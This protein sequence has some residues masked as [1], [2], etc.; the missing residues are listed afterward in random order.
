MALEHIIVIYV[1]LWHW[2]QNYIM[3]Y[4]LS[5]SWQTS[6]V[7]HI[8]TFHHPAPRPEINVF[9]RHTCILSDS[10]FVFFFNAASDYSLISVSLFCMPSR[11]LQQFNDIQTKEWTGYWEDRDISWCEGHFSLPWT[12]KAQAQLS[13]WHTL[14]FLFE[15][16][17]ACRSVQQWCTLTC[18]WRPSITVREATWT[19]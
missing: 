1:S 17:M 13:P 14:C 8:S 12:L 15:V 18:A 19:E 11:V 5:P 16:S 10:F 9:C 7:S 6:R 3:F 2:Q 4:L